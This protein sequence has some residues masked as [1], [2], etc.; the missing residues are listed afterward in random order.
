[1]QDDMANQILGDILLQLHVEE[2]VWLVM[3]VWGEIK[4]FKVIIIDIFKQGSKH[5]ADHFL[6][7]FKLSDKHGGVG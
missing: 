3:H 4:V 2:K 7:E 5:Q 1:M 6:D